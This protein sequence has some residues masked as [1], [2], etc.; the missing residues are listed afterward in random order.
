MRQASAHSNVEP[1]RLVKEHRALIQRL[2][3]E[4]PVL[5]L[6]C[7][8]GRN[9]LYLAALEIPV[10]FADRDPQALAAIAERLKT[11]HW[12]GELW[13]V[14]LEQGTP[15][16]GSRFA[17]VLV[18]NYLHRPLLEGIRQ[19]VLP[20]GLLLYE[21]FTREQAQY[22]R[23]SNP[24]YLLQAGELAAGFADWEILQ[25]EEGIERDDTGAVRRAFANVV[26]RKPVTQTEN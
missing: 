11:Q 10:I 21:T 9:G 8:L 2:S 26:A 6:A 4:G 17:V 24:D 5:D 7:G 25:S 16:S 14:D 18:F 3:R 22:G 19:S 15:L 12:P 23:P 20:G 1:S 13:Q